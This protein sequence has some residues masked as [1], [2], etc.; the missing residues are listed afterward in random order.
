MHAYYNRWKTEEAPYNVQHG[1]HLER[2]KTR[3]SP[4][5]IP[6]NGGKK[7]H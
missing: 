6:V 3:E 4:G 5:L 1:L 2:F 7:H